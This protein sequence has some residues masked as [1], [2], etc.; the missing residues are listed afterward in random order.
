MDGREVNLT[1]WIWACEDVLERSDGA[2]E[3]TASHAYEAT[4]NLLKQIDRLFPTIQLEIYN[5]SRWALMGLGYV[6]FMIVP[7]LIGVIVMALMPMQYLNAAT[8]VPLVLAFVGVGF[9]HFWVKPRT[10]DLWLGKYLERLVI[11][12]YRSWWRGMIARFHAATH[13]SHDQVQMSASHLVYQQHEHLNVSTWLP[14][15]YA[16]D[17][18]MVLYASAVRFLR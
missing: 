9:F 15:L 1:P 11:R 7:T 8:F 13:F 18:A 10:F 3:V 16:V 17:A 2:V 4:F 6:F 5:L 12:N 14:R